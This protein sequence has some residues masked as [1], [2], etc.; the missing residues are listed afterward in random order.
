MLVKNPW[1]RP[2]GLANLPPLEVGVWHKLLFVQE[3]GHLRAAIDGRWA[4]DLQDDAFNSSGP[5][6]N[7]GCIGLRLMYASR[8]RFKN[9]KIWNRDMPVEER[10]AR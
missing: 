5:V 6:L 1:I 10:P 9:L 7:S 4:L 2:L 3:G 8:M